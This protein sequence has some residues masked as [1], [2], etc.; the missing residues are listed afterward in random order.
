MRVKQDWCNIDPAGDADGKF[1]D[2]KNNGGQIID[3]ILEVVE[4]TG[5]ENVEADTVKAIY[6]ITGRK[7]ENIT[8]GGIYIVNGKKVLVK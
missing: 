4:A 6:D 3:V 8:K 5:I 7:I 1:D 2:F